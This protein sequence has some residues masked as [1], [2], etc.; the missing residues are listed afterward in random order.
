VGHDGMSPRMV[1]DTIS[2]AHQVTVLRGFEA[3]LA[4]SARKHK[5]SGM[6]AKTRVSSSEIIENA[7][8]AVGIYRLPPGR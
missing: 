3:A 6:M 8:S 2:V 4:K 7:H 5:E 1:S